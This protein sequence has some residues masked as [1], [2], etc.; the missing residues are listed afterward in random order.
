MGTLKKIITYT[1]SPSMIGMVVVVV[2]Y[3]LLPKNNSTAYA[4]RELLII[5]RTQLVLLALELCCPR[6]SN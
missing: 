4:W 5:M 2:R 6:P 3:L 1:L